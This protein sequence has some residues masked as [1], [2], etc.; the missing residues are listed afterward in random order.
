MLKSLGFQ[1]SQG[2]SLIQYIEY[3]NTRDLRGFKDF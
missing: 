1:G 2:P 3:F